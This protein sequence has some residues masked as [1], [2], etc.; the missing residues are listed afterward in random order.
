MGNIRSNKF[1]L[2]INGLMDKTCSNPDP[3]WEGPVSENINHSDLLLFVFYLS[4]WC[5]AS[6]HISSLTYL[7]S[8]MKKSFVL[9]SK[10]WREV[11]ID[12]ES[13]SLRSFKIKRTNSIVS[14]ESHSLFYKSD[15][16]PNHT[17]KRIE[18]IMFLYLIR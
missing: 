4:R 16:S 6:I 14:Y 11:L 10:F 5:L 17:H 3:E 1:N 18:L 13:V 7:N 8:K 9:E 12:I 15:T 2:R